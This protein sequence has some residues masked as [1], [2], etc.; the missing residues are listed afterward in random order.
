MP[1]P[2]LDCSI[3]NAHHETISKVL[4]LKD[5][6]VQLEISR[7][8]MGATWKTAHEQDQKL[9]GS[10][11]LQS[12]LTEGELDTLCETFSS[13][14]PGFIHGA[15]SQQGCLRVASIINSVLVRASTPPSAV[16]LPF[17]H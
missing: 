8:E 3:L 1:E 14:L 4:L 13:H 5:G 12:E 7:D 15:T 2:L 9:K 10:S 11:V 6:I 17:V 16:R